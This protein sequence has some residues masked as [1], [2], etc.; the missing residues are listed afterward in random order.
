MREMAVEDDRSDG[1]ITVSAGCCTVD[2]RMRRQHN[3]RQY[4]TMMEYF[5]FV[6]RCTDGKFLVLHTPLLK[7]CSQ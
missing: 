4:T 3:E 2:V 1:A 6:S 5:K 7:I